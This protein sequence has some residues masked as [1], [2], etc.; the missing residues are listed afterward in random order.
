MATTSSPVP[1]PPIS[2]SP[3]SLLSATSNNSHTSSTPNPASPPQFDLRPFPSTSSSTTSPKLPETSP[4]LTK[5]ETRRR[6]RLSTPLILEGVVRE[7]GFSGRES[8]AGFSSSGSSDSTSGGNGGSRS[9]RRPSIRTRTLSLSFS[10][11]D[12]AFTPTTMQPSQSTVAAA[13]FPFPSPT[14]PAPPSAAI[15]PLTS[16]INDGR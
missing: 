8:E 6:N 15:Q 16:V 10:P 3:G 14:P 11:R 7:G 2:S 4:P 5:A 1:S 12:Q 9:R 13:S